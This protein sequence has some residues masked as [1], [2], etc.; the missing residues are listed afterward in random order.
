[1]DNLDSI[2][3]AAGVFGSVTLGALV[4]LLMQQVKAFYPGL[5]GRASEVAVVGVSFAA[6]LLV[7]LSVRADPRALDTYLA[8][9]IGT[10]GT[11]VIA[12]G[13]Y[14]Q[15]YHQKVAGLPPDEGERI[16]AVETASED[17]PEFGWRRGR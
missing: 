3:I 14:S 6:V 16:V 17:A 15:L 8:L 1:M 10:L 4:M 5:T 13:V 9:V 11:T 7:L 12:R 2:T